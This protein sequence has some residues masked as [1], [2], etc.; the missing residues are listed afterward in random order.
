MLV[1]YVVIADGNLRR[2]AEEIK[3]NWDQIKGKWKQAKGQVQEK[4]G[5]LTDDDL[6]VV[7]GKRE[8]LVGRVQE[9]YGVAREEA[10]QQVKEFEDCCKC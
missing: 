9:R 7:D 2:I 1:L 3:M 5:E 6:A 4:W 10:E 8:V